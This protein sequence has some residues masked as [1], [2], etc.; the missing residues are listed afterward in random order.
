MLVEQGCKCRICGQQ[1]DPKPLN[2][3]GFMWTTIHETKAVRGLLCTKCNSMIG[4]ALENVE[5]LK[6]RSTTSITSK[7]IHQG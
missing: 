4:H 1:H 6:K 3:A 2:A 5:I 7:V